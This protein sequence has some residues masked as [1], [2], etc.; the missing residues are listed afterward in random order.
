M[1]HYKMVTTIVILAELQAKKCRPK[2]A[3]SLLLFNYIISLFIEKSQINQSQ[4]KV[5][6][7]TS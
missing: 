3:R 4:L 6:P 5:L 7:Q 1:Y 2:S